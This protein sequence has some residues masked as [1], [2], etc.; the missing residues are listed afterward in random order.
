M[1]YYAVLVGLGASVAVVSVL[2]G[3]LRHWLDDLLHHRRPNIWQRHLIGATLTGLIA[4]GVAYATRFFELTDHG[5]ELVLGPRRMG[6]PHGPD[7]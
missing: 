7:G 2:F 5:L 3:R 4:L 1:R 6:H